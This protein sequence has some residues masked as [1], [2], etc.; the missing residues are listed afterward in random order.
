[1]KAV[2]MGL[3]WGKNRTAA[4]EIVGRRSAP[5]QEAGSVAARLAGVLKSGVMLRK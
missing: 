2:R 4:G 1:M 5:G 3:W